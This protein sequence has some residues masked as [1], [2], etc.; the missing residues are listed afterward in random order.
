VYDVTAYLPH[1]PAGPRAILKY[2][3]TDAARHF[4]FH[5]RAAR[6]VWAQFEIGRIEGQEGACTVM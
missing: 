1:H 2:A 3:G 6:D 5:P 4:D